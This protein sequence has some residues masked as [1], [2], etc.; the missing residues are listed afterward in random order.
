MIEHVKRIQ[1]NRLS[2]GIIEWGTT[3]NAKEGKTRKK[4]KDGWMEYDEV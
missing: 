2:W 4:K 1:E 3:G